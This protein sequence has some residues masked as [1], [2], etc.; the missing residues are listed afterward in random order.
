M[1]SPKALNPSALSQ[2]GL[3]TKQKS[4]A[5]RTHIPAGNPT[6]SN[7]PTPAAVSKNSNHASAPEQSAAFT[8]KGTGAGA[9]RSAVSTTPA[10]VPR[11]SSTAHLVPMLAPKDLSMRPK[12]TSSTI[13]DGSLDITLEAQ[14][15]LHKPGQPQHNP[16]SLINDVVADYNKMFHKQAKIPKMSTNPGTSRN[17]WIIHQVPNSSRVKLVSP[18]LRASPGQREWCTYIRAIWQ[19]FVIHWRVKQGSYSL[20]VDAHCKTHLRIAIPDDYPFSHLKR[21]AQAAAHF[22]TALRNLMPLDY[23]GAEKAVRNWAGTKLVA[24]IEACKTKEDVM[25]LM[26]PR[27]DTY[28]GFNFLKLN[29]KVIEFCPGAACRTMNDFFTCA[30]VAMRFFRASKNMQT[31]ADILK[32]PTTINGFNDFMKRGGVTGSDGVYL[33]TL[34][35]DYAS[36]K[37]P[38]PITTKKVTDTGA[39]GVSNLKQQNKALGTK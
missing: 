34:L 3:A 14:F 24:A 21:L 16:A 38:K 28:L 15:I 11:D 7:L 1:S 8:K 6:R 22:E 20:S 4:S 29:S 32:F 31:S 17:F 36:H 10:T 19:F 37:T 39:A 5:H 26:N 18:V 27:G 12:I 33:R 2:P 23:V 9:V 25:N 13:H 35:M 30:V